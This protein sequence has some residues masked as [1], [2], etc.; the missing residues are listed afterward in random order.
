MGA[1]VA[2]ALSA[3]ERRSRNGIELTES[4][5]DHNIHAPKRVVACLYSL[6]LALDPRHRPGA[7]HRLLINDNVVDAFKLLLH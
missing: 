1:V 6:E 7:R 3:E 5:G 2:L 4:A